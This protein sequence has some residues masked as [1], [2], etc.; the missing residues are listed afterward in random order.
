MPQYNSH[1]SCGIAC[2]SAVPRRS[3]IY[4]GVWYCR[5]IFFSKR[6]C[7]HC[8]DWKWWLILD[9]IRC[10]HDGWAHSV[11]F[12]C[13]FKESHPFDP[14]IVLALQC[15]YLVFR[16]SYRYKLPVEWNTTSGASSSI[17]D[18]DQSKFRRITHFPNQSVLWVKDSRT[19]G[20]STIHEPSKPPPWVRYT[21]TW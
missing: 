16:T 9:G 2:D 10:H 21:R 12:F 15:R 3:K 20:V 18:V 8:D 6:S 4:G 17:D 14:K 7:S 5:H 13:A 19:R 1:K 11:V